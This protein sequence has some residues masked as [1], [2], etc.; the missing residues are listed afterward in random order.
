MLSIFL[1]LHWIIS[2]RAS[3]VARVPMYPSI[4]SLLLSLENLFLPLNP[5]KEFLHFFSG[6]SVQSNAIMKED[7]HFTK[8][9]MSVGL[10]GHLVRKRV[11][12]LGKGC[13]VKTTSCS[14]I[15]CFTPFQVFQPTHVFASVSRSSFCT[16]R[17]FEPRNCYNF[18]IGWG[19]TVTFWLV[20]TGF[21]DLYVFIQVQTVYKKSTKL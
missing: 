4:R 7:L 18:K 12:C 3:L 16:C 2:W 6:V 8:W 20:L 9:G 14:S 15:L 21:E 19:V 5:I 10:C 13:D 1:V 17:R 11:R